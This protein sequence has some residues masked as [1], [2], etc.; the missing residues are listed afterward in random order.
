MEV[1][2]DLNPCGPVKARVV[3]LKLVEDC[4]DRN[5]GV[6]R[7]RDTQLLDPRRFDIG[8]DEVVRTHLNCADATLV[9]R[10]GCPAVFHPTLFGE[11]V[12][13]RNYFDGLVVIGMRVVHE[14]E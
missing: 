6:K 9:E 3:L 11:T 5:A 12:I 2:D 10:P 8:Q 13:L 7:P 4:S 14:V 1:E